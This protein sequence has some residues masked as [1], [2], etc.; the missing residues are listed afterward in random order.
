MDL[1]GLQGYNLPH[2]GLL[3]KLQRKALCSGISNT[4]FFTDHGVCRV[5]SLAS[6]HSSLSTGF[7]PQF[8]LALVKYVITEVLPPSLIGSALARSG[9]ILEPAGAG[10]IRHGGSSSQLLAEVAPIAPL[11][12]KPCHANPQQRDV[13]VLSKK[14]GCD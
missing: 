6:S 2:H 9:S 13:E 7:S 5:V 8:F 12:P 3:H 14:E 10:F 1:H 4:S 11:L